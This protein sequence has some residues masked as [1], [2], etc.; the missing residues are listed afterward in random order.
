MWTGTRWEGKGDWGWRSG[1]PQGCASLLSLILLIPVP[2][3]LLHSILPSLCSVLYLFPQLTGRICQS[4]VIIEISWQPVLPTVSQF[5]APGKSDIQSISV[6]QVSQTTLL[7]GRSFPTL[8][9]PL[10]GHYE[11]ERRPLVDKVRELKSVSEEWYDL[12]HKPSRE[13]PVWERIASQ[14][15]KEGVWSENKRIF[16]SFSKLTMN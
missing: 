4:Q 3:P 10:L 12:C 6:S 8:V 2:G 9:Q 15:L 13:E 14:K 5:T 11:V 1:P 16:A 7:T